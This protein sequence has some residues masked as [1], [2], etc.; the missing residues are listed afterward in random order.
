MNSIGFI[1]QD[2]D[3][4]EKLFPSDIVFLEKEY[5]DTKVWNCRN[6]PFGLGCAGR[7]E[8]T[9]FGGYRICIR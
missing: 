8:T 2:N 9:P 6:G 3:E 5:E 4:D 7:Q 1:P